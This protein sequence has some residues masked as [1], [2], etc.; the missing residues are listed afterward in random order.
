MG[1][2]SGHRVLATAWS[3]PSRAHTLSG[4]CHLRTTSLSE[5]QGA[6]TGIVKHGSLIDIVLELLVADA[7]NVVARLRVSSRDGMQEASG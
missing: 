1:R 4:S 3:I 7:K 2:S 6:Q 5:V